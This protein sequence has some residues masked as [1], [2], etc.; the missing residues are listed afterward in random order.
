M[1]KQKSEYTVSADPARLDLEMIT[2]FL[3]EESYWARGI[4]LD[5]MRRAAAG[6]FCVGVYHGDRQ[7]A[8]ARVVT[9][10]A[11]FGHIMDVFVLPEHRGKGLGKVLMESIVTHPRLQGF[12]RWQ[13]GT[14]D[15]HGLYARYG[16]TALAHPQRHMEK[17]DTD[18]DRRAGAR[19]QTST[20]S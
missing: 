11:T 10:Y 19:R 20:P 8:F 13:L 4:P 3:A 6:S 5:V 14:D 16:F 2:R 15:A 18:V 7:V 12:R 1:D 17:T 9:D